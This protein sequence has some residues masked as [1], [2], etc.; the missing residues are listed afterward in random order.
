M[1]PHT[2]VQTSHEDVSVPS[3]SSTETGMR[4]NKRLDSCR[5]RG[6]GS[7]GSPRWA[8]ATLPKPFFM[9]P[10]IRTANPWR[11]RRTLAR[12]PLLEGQRWKMLSHLPGLKRVSSSGLKTPDEEK[13]VQEKDLRWTGFST[14]YLHWASMISVS[15]HFSR[16]CCSFIYTERW[17]RASTSQKVVEFGSRAAEPKH[18]CL[19]SIKNV[20]EVQRTSANICLFFYLFR[21]LMRVTGYVGSQQK[22]EKHL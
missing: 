8:P 13:N 18:K 16:I 20:K 11:K 1:D 2:S 6:D 4:G 5:S 3:K 17:W 15:D 9:E 10:Y 14:F 21:M 7:S 19:A 22:R 12:L